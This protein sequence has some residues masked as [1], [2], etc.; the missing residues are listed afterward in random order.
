MPKIPTCGWFH[1]CEDCDIITSRL[2]SVK[3][4]KKQKTISVCQNCRIKF[5]YYLLDDFH[6]VVIDHESAGEMSLIVY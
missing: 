2:V 4:K 5:I 6:T 3:H 1:M